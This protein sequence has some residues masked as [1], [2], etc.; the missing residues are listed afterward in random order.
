MTG[1]V[2]VV[3]GHVGRNLAAGMSGGT[4]YLYDPL[5]HVHDHLSAGVYEIDPLEYEDDEHLLSLLER[6]REE[7]GSKKAAGLLANWRNERMNFVRI[8][9]SEYQR[10]RDELR[11]G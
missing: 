6:Y 2:I 5:G 8:E 11:N 9:T 7:T 1:G 3:L 4:L 10:I